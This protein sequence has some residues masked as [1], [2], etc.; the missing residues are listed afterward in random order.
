MNKKKMFSK[1]KETDKSIQSNDKKKKNITT[2]IVL[3]GS[4]SSSVIGH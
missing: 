4:G 3:Q 2:I 1:H